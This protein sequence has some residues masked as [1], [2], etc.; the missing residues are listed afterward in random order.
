MVSSNNVELVYD[1]V[2]NQRNI[3]ERG[4]PFDLAEF[5]LSDP[6]MKWEIDERRNH[7]RNIMAKIAKKTSNEIRKEWT[8]KKLRALAA[9][10][11]SFPDET[12]DEDIATGSVRHMGRGFASYN[13]YINRMGRPKSAVRKVVVGIRL[14]EDVVIDMRA[15]NGYSSL[16]ADY[17]MKGILSGKLKIPNQ[18]AKS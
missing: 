7:G 2:K 15:T 5:V 4:L 6:N 11:P 13:E 18:R 10:V 16:L 12:T 14:P 1:P 9:E 3:K 8:T 17:I